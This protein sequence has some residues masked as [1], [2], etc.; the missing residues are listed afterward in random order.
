MKNFVE[1]SVILALGWAL[2]VFQQPQSAGNAG[3]LPP[4]FRD[5]FTLRIRIDKKHFYEE[6]FDKVPYVS[7]GDVYVFA[8]ESFG[9]NAM[10]Q[11]GEISGLSYE[12]QPARAD[13]QFSFRQD[14][15]N[16]KLLML[17][18][19]KNGLK[20]RLYMDALITVPERKE[21]LKTSILPIDPGLSDFE[22]WPHP[23]VQLVLRDFLRI[24]R[25]S[26]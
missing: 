1:C 4:Q 5:P 20:R 13:V 19:I 17:L 24:P 2:P 14:N 23:I 26:S 18:T 10:I 21:I 9:V 25:I 15:S 3:A 16:G 6:Q 7:D 22:S 11:A 8:G 12:K